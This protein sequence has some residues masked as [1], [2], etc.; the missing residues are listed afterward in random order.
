[1]TNYIRSTPE[2][3]VSV[4]EL[5]GL[6]HNGN[7]SVRITLC[8]DTRQSSFFDGYGSWKPIEFS[9]HFSL[10]AGVS[11][12]WLESL[13]LKLEVIHERILTEDKV[14]GECVISLG[15]MRNGPMSGW[16][17]LMYQG[18]SRGKVKLAIKASHMPSPAASATVPLDSDT[19]SQILLNRKKHQISVSSEWPK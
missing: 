8:S 4:H 15:T 17:P 10:I 3:A 1:M 12:N 6:K 14:V 16:F 19:R 5:S 2:L 13:A 18:S 11:P 9:A 7:H